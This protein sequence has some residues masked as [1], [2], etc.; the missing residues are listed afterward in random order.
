MLIRNPTFHICANCGFNTKNMDEFKFHKINCES[1]NKKFINIDFTS[2]NYSSN[3]NEINRKTSEDISIINLL[4][5]EKEKESISD[6]ESNSIEKEDSQNQFLNYH[7]Q[8]NIPKFNY[9]SFSNDKTLI[10]SLS[11]NFM[12]DSLL[13]QSN[14]YNLITQNNDS[15]GNF[16]TKCKNIIISPSNY[17]KMKQDKKC[18]ICQNLKIGDFI[19]IFE[20]QHIIHYDCTDKIIKDECILCYEIK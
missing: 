4:S 18:I 14:N 3:I 13:N 6:F 17:Q 5:I 9:S 12:Q 20:C 19:I 8:L 2:E 10:N 1:K 15:I 7:N 16:F 11:Q